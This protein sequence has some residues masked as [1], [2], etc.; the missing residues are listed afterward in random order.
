MSERC[1]RLVRA[2]R[3]A[4]RQ[5]RRAHAAS[6]AR[7][8]DLERAVPSA[9]RRAR[10]PRR[11]RGPGTSL[12]AEHKRRSP[13][14]GDIRRRARAVAEIVAAYERGGAAALSVLT[15]EATLRRLARRP[16]R[17]PRGDRTCR[18]CART[19][20][21]T[22]TA[23]RGRGRRR[24]C[25]AAVVGRGARRGPGRALRGGARELDLD[26]IVEVH[27]ARG[28]G[29]GAR[30][31]RRRDRHQQPRPRRLHRRR[32]AH[33][34]AAGRR[35]GRQDGRLGVGYRAT[36]ADRGARAGRRGRGAGRRERSCAPTI[37][38]GCAASWCAS[39]R[40]S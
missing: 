27:D 10:S 33:V 25:R 8:R 21:S 23:L 5:R 20:R 32:R 19:S 39:L 15:E 14:A 7:R 9:P 6:G 1:E 30:D 29:D 11:W 13:S 16:A 34:R 28:A 2:D 24:R 17:G 26:A 37:Q 12:I 4:V 3:A 35:P 22:A 36:R 31:R 18:S 38:S 40:T